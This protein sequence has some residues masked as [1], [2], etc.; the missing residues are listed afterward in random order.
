MIGTLSRLLFKLLASLGAL[1]TAAFGAFLYRKQRKAASPGEPRESPVPSASVSRATFPAATPEGA[2]VD[3]QSQPIHSSD[4]VEETKA[5]K[6]PE[7][8]RS[9]LRFT[10]VLLGIGLLLLGMFGFDLAVRGLHRFPAEPRLHV[11]DSDVARGRAALISYGCG[12]CH[13]IPG[14]PNA[15][16]RV[17]PQLIGFRDQIYIA[18]MLPNLPDNLTAWIHDP[19]RF[20]PGTAM[21]NLNV[22]EGEARDM[23]AYIYANP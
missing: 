15:T 7:Q 14:I 2:P 19:K 13:V 20:N 21:P 16:G 6:Q 3:S 18:G 4:P 23:A 17:G 1:L 5:E 11:P 8:Q 10:V 12:S 9:S 22:T